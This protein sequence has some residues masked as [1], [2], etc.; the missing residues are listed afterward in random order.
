MCGA[1]VEVRILGQ[2]ERINSYTFSGCN[3]LQSLHL[4]KS[5][6]AIHAS[7]IE[8][9]NNLTIYAPVGSYAE[10]FAAKNGIPFSAE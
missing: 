9:T 5:V 8:R 4:P 2:V 7:A 1:L 3:K 6:K 10:K